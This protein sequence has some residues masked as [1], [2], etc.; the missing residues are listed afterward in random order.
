[1]FHCLSLCS[2]VQHHAYTVL[3]EPCMH[4]LLSNT[5]SISLWRIVDAVMASIAG[6]LTLITSAVLHA[7]VD[8]T[9]RAFGAGAGVR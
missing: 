1:M 8:E 4:A 3:V 2:V 7:G 9:C 5:C 6:V